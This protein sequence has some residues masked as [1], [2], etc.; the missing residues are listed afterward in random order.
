MQ[1][2]SISQALQ[3]PVSSSRI[4]RDPEN[5]LRVRASSILSMEAT[6]VSLLTTRSS[7]DRA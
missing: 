4:A 6:S 5:I 3:D 7:L 2:I 1:L